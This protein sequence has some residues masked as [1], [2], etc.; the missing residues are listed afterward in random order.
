MRINKNFASVLV[1]FVASVTCVGTVECVTQ[2]MLWSDMP[3][4]FSEKH[5]ET[6]RH[7]GEPWPEV[8][9]EYRML[10]AE[11]GEA[12]D[13]DEQKAVLGERKSKRHKMRN[14][15]Y[16]EEVAKV[17]GTGGQLSAAQL[18][19]CKLRYFT[20]GVVLG[21]REFV[22]RFFTKM[23][24]QRPESHTKPTTG[25]W[26]LRYFTRTEIYSLRDLRKDVYRW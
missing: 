4:V 3:V 6:M 14:G 21:S 9:G 22:D 10:V 2:R 8:M 18:L 26:K 15:F 11:E 7:S 13:Q 25:A 20:D 12:A 1:T 16:S 19:H 17:L 23:K 24:E 5:A